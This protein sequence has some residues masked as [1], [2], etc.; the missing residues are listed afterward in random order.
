MPLNDVSGPTKF[1]L[2]IFQFL[3]QPLA[4][5]HHRDHL[6]RAF[7]AEA[8][9]TD[10]D[11]TDAVD[12]GICANRDACTQAG[13]CAVNVAKE[14]AK[15]RKEVDTLKKRVNELE[16]EVSQQK[17]SLQGDDTKV[18]F[19]TS[20][21]SYEALQAFYTFLNSSVDDL[22]CLKFDAENQEGKGK[23]CRSWTLP[24]MEEFFLTLVR[25]QLGLMEQ[26]F[27]YRFDISAIYSF[28]N[29]NHLD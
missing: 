18:S 10:S 28:E 20:F 1:L 29:N 8:P 2:Y 24:P 3:W 11:D 13:E 15:L 12:C 17:F 26:D 9:D 21:P 27:A 22:S 6:K 23:R 16:Q 4:G 7:E 5:R 14:V 25:L 19:Y